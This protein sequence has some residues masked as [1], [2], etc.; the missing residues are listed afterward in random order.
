MLA[1]VSVVMAV[2]FVVKF[3]LCAC[4]DSRSTLTSSARKV[5]VPPG[6][7]TASV[8]KYVTGSLRQ[9]KFSAA[10]CIPIDSLTSQVKVTI[11]PGHAKSLPSSSKLDDRLTPTVERTGHDNSVHVV[12]KIKS[13]HIK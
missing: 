12:K 11:S 5:L 3:A 1:V 4:A 10:I 13:H 8:G 2:K 6:L 9:M 7:P